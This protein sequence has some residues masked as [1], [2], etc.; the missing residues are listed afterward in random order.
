[1]LFLGSEKQMEDHKNKPDHKKN[2][3]TAEMNP[4]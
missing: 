2:R 1:M 3:D 4:S